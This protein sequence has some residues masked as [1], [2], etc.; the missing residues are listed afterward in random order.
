MPGSGFGA[1]G[2]G[3]ATDGS[4][5][6]YDAGR[7]G[8]SSLSRRAARTHTG[9][10][11]AVDAAAGRLIVVARTHRWVERPL[12]LASVRP[13]DFAVVELEPEAWGADPA[14]ARDLAAH[15]HASRDG[16]PPPAKKSPG[17]L[18]LRGD[19]VAVAIPPRGSRC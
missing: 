16:L 2:A 12:D 18:R 17:G 9:N 10:V 1:S 6:F 7:E 13:G 14:P 5:S 4:R 11:V 3:R 15:R 8:R 19:I